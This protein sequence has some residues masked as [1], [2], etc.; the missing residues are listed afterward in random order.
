[1]PAKC[2]FLVGNIVGAPLAAGLVE[3]SAPAAAESTTTRVGRWMSEA[4]YK[5]MVKTGEV[6]APLN[7]AGATHVT[8]PPDP[9]AFKPPPQSTKFVEFDVPK[10]QVRVHDPGKGWGRVFGP[11]SLEARSAAAKGLPVPTAMPP[12]TNIKVKIP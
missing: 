4:E 12:A 8:V 10:T 9:S 7:G 11:G 3:G 6:Q 1:D 5:A 2:G